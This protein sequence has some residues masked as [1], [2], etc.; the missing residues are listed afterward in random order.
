MIGK[1]VLGFIA[2]SFL[3]I[4]RGAYTYSRQN[5][6]NLWQLMSAATQSEYAPFGCPHLPYSE[7]ARRASEAFKEHIDTSSNIVIQEG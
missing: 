6:A 5:G 3:P 1:L 7:A 4:W 2:F